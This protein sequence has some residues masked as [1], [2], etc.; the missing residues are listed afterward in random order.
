[1]SLSE[2]VPLKPRAMYRGNGS[3][4]P[5]QQIA[6]HLATITK[7][8]KPVCSCPERR[9][10]GG[11]IVA[12]QNLTKTIIASAHSSEAKP[13]PRL[14]QSP[15]RQHQVLGMPKRN[16]PPRLQRC[17]SGLGSEKCT[18]ALAAATPIPV[19]ESFLILQVNE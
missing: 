4:L 8:N 17:P 10:R 9:L 19:L 5:R 11:E 3:S 2:S 6:P 14:R 13:S 15:V 18:D 7:R 16:S 12:H 1:M